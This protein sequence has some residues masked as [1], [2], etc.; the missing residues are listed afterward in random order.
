MGVTIFSST[1]FIGGTVSYARDIEASLMNLFGATVVDFTLDADT[2]NFSIVDGALT[3]TDVVFTIQ[4]TGVSS[5]LSYRVFTEV[6]GGDT[7]LC[8]AILATSPDPLIYSG[9]LGTLGSPDVSEDSGLSFESPW[10]VALDLDDEATLDPG[11]FCTIRMNVVGWHA[12]RNEITSKYLDDEYLELTFTQE[13]P[14]PFAFDAGTLSLESLSVM[15]TEDTSDTPPITEEEASSDEEGESAGGSSTEDTV[16]PVAGEQE[17]VV[18]EET[19]EEELTEEP[20]VID[21]V[22]E[23]ETTTEEATSEEPLEV[24]EEG[25]EEPS[26]PEQPVEE[27]TPIE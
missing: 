3:D 9:Q 25:G 12:Q 23:G 24:T 8:E 2:T 13:V 17:N 18:I 10:T 14:V 6:V 5:E 16:P 22:V 26:E 1:Y 19:P 20:T 15:L 4:K 7:A 27:T 21:E 11:T